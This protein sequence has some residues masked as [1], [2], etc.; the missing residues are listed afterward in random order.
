MKAPE[1]KLFSRWAAI[2]VLVAAP[3]AAGAQAFPT[4]P[5]TLI[6]GYAPGTGPDSLAR[7][8]SDTLSKNLGQPVVVDNKAGALGQIAASFVAKSPPDGYTV[9]LADQ[10]S[11]A[12]LPLAKKPPPYDP[13]AEFVQVGEIA[14]TDFA[15]IVS[16]QRQYKTIKD[17]VDSQRKNSR[18]TAAIF[19]LPAQV[20][21]A[22]FAE[23]A[24]LTMEPINYRAPGEGIAS[25]A[26]GDVDGAFVSVPFAAAQVKGGRVAALMQTGQERSKLLPDVP[27]ATE[28]G[29]SDLTFTAWFAMAAPANTPPEVVRRLNAGMVATLK[30]PEVIRKLEGAGFQPVGSSPDQMKTLLGNELNKWRPLIERAG[31]R[32][33]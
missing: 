11:M 21:S 2:A 1:F 31:I 8:I 13:I 27:T 24:G 30:D 6:V 28:A 15:W 16:S 17:F 33:N 23:K 18:T 26:S 19:G 7:F 20:F 29:F 12:F 9:L 22:F 4:R 5:V 32:A 14:R 3:F 25:L 10:G